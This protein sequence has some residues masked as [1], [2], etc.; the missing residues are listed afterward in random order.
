[1]SFLLVHLDVYLA[2]AI[3]KNSHH[4]KARH[5]LSRIQTLLILWSVERF[6]PSDYIPDTLKVSKM[7]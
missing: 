1:M 4:L 5:V 6:L 2:R 7:L 3:V